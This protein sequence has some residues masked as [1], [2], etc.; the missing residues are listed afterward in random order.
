MEIMCS[1]YPT[2]AKLLNIKTETFDLIKYKVKTVK[3]V[4]GVLKII[5]EKKIER[6]LYDKNEKIRRKVNNNLELYQLILKE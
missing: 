2:H 5:D 4:R 6:E 1:C 3:K